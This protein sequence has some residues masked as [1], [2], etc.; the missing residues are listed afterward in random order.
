MSFSS[1]NDL[2]S[3]IVAGKTSSF[4]WSK[5]TGGVATAGRWYDG[6]ILTGTP[7]SNAFAGTNLAWT[8]CDENTG[9]GTQIFG[10]PHGGNVSPDT[11]HVVSASLYGLVGT[12]A[13][14]RLLL[15][16]LQGYWP[17][18]STASAAAQT[19]TGTPSLRYT[20]GQGCRL[21]FVQTVAAGAT[22]HNITL[23]YTNSGGTSGRSLPRT[24]AMTPSAVASHIS[25]SGSTSGA[26]NFVDMFLPLAAG[27]T[28][29]QNVASVTMSA[30][31]GAGSGAL[32]LAKPLLS[33]S[34]PTS[35]VVTERDYINQ[36][37][38]LPRVMDGACL[39]WLYYAGS[40]L[41]ASTPL[42]GKL[43]FAWG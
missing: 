10:I 32:C 6:S 41:A 38:S 28:G 12:T 36:L 7:R 30:S 35:A 42:Y 27:D 34:I 43:D 11:K 17:G 13:L 26:D 4:N 39:V 8:T 18:I 9:N 21:Y 23:S 31:S 37:P 40:A 1:I 5:S 20:N 15:V 2:V 29:V 24:V 33:I 25:H 19:L 22:A 16:D 14:A 3:E